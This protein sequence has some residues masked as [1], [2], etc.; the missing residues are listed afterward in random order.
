MKTEYQ[1]CWEFRDG[2]LHPV[3]DPIEGGG[4]VNEDIFACGYRQEISSGAGSDSSSAEVSLYKNHD[5]KNGKP[6]FYI[7]VMGAF[8]SIGSL[9]ANDF[10]Q[11][12]STLNHLTGL[13]AL[14]KL[15]QSSSLSCLTIEALTPRP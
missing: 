8:E 6:L 12:A 15:D 13:L 11:L 3:N 4:D 9:I 7:D 5:L 10:A 14:V 2:G 1:N